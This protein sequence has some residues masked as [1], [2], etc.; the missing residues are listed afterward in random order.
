MYHPN[1]SYA[2]DI[3]SYIDNGVPILYDG[4]QCSRI[5]KNW[6]STE[7][8]RDDVKKN[9]VKD[10]ELGRKS[11]PFEHPPFRDFIGSPMGA[12]KKKRSAKVRVIHD[13]SWPPNEGVNQRIQEDR[14]LF[15]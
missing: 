6:K 2:T 9:I 8:F 4:P 12:F 13:L 5:C 7:T 15:F 10:V 1:R 14:S 3:L 11:G